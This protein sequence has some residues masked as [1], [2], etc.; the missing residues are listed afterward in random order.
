MATLLFAPLPLAGHVNPTLKL[1]RTL[2]ARGH[3]VVYCSLR[4]VEEPL[5]AAGFEFVPVFESIY[6][7]GVLAELPERMSRLR[8]LPL[9]RLALEHIRLRDAMLQAVLDGEYDR[10]LE[11]VGPDLVLC[12]ER[13]VELPMVCHGHGVRAVRLNTT[14]PRHLVHML[15]GSEGRAGPGGPAMA[16][17]KGLEAL[18]GR[19]R[20][21]PRFQWYH[22]RIALKHGCPLEPV[23]FPPFRLP[24]LP[25]LVLFPPSF[26]RLGAAEPRERLHHLGPSIDLERQEP[27]FPWERLREGPPLILF[28]LGTMA[29]SSKLA[30]RLL[31]VVCETAARRPDWQFIL[32]VGAAL[33]P[34]TFDG[35]S[36]TVIAVRHAP[37]LQLLRRASVMITHSGFNSVKECIYFGVPMVALPMTNDQ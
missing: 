2:R 26:A 23:G 32:A 6:P 35:A 5:R 7:K 17:L 15:P 31:R 11:A 12:D 21:A 1:A 30:P 36:P 19:L 3:R 28:S 29:F 18:L 24:R 27:D 4:D 37:Q 20:V 34:A 22:Q 10:V 33:D 13:V 8:G 9:L 25:D 14:L 16:L